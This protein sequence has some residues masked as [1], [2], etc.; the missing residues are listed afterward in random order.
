MTALEGHRNLLLAAG[1][2]YE[3]NR[4]DRPKPFNVFTVLRSASDEVN[5]HSRFLHALLDHVDPSSGKRDNLEQFLHE[6]VEVT[7]FNLEQ[8]HVERESNYIDLLIS[9]GHQAIVIENK[10]WAG[11]QEL[12][13]Q[14]YRDALVARRYKDE[15]IRLLYL[16][17]HGHEPSRKSSGELPEDQIDC[18]SYRNDLPN[19]LTGCQRRA[20]DDPGLRESIAQY[21][22]LIRH[23]TNTDHEG[24]NMKELK[25]LLLRDDNLV[26]ARRLFP[27]YVEAEVE[28][29]RKFYCIVDNEL[30]QRI[31]DLPQ[32]DPEW[33]SYAEEDRI[34]RCVEGRRSS[35]CGLYYRITEVAWLFVGG[36]DRLYVSLEIDEEANPDS[37]GKLKEAL[38]GLGSWGSSDDN[39]LRWYWLDELPGW[40]DT[41]EWFHVREA[42]E[43][44]LKFLLSGK[45]SHIE[46]AKS[47]A[48]KV[49]ELCDAIKSRG[50]FRAG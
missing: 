9:D 24:Q 23:M 49:K 1:R 28:L 16:T 34:R 6:V 27:A 20:F 3:R 13:L 30:H 2:I 40:N 4:I 29:V 50:L 44:S 21:I 5:L 7:D 19:W 35:W 17:P 14:R 8:A 22:R 43:P 37:H 39:H 47:I 45:K 41:G 26:L 25:E 31:E 38:A 11:D 46:F 48:N 42:N 15:D 12:Q 18:L 36:G 10:I 32:L 33:A